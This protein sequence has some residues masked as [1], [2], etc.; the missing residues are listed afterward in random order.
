MLES[1][2]IDE[3]LLVGE[4]KVSVLFFLPRKSTFYLFDMIIIF[5]G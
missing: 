3:E 2:M 5:K 4:R 1:Y